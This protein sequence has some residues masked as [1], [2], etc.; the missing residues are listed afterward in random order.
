MAL[1]TTSVVEVRDALPERISITES[2]KG[3]YFGASC[4]ITIAYVTFK[5]TDNHIK[6]TLSSHS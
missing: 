5:F 2:A 4:M 6:S 1:D 3:W